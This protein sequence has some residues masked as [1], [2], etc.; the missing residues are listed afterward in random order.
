[1]YSMGYERPI[2]SLEPFKYCP[3]CA[4]KLGKQSQAKLT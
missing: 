2:D 3:W 1:M 4:K